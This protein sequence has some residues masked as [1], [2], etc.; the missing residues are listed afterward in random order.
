MGKCCKKCIGF[1]N[2]SHVLLSHASNEHCD[3]NT[4]LE[5]VTEQESVDDSDQVEQRQVQGTCCSFAKLG[6]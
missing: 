2:K 1:G 4:Q 5:K 6:K 3:K